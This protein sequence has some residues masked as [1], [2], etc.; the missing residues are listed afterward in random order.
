V[1]LFDEIRTFFERN[2]RRAAPPLAN[3]RH[4]AKKFSSHFLSC[5]PPIFS[6]PPAP[7][8]RWAGKRKRKLFCWVLLST[9]RAAGLR[10]G[11]GEAEFPPPP[12]FRLALA[13]GGHFFGGQILFL[14]PHARRG[15]S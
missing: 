13:S 12:P 3:A 5:A 11:S 2:W 6:S 10:F 8:L 9:S 1:R 15:K 7:R 14:A 4:P